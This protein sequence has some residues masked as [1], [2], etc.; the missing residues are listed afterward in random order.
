MKP[1]CD[2]Y[3]FLQKMNLTELATNEANETI[4]REWIRD[5]NGDIICE[6]LTEDELFHADSF[7]WWVEGIF[8]IVVGAI[9]FIANFAAIPILCSK[10][11]ISM[12]NRLLT[13]L[14]IIDNVF[15]AVSIS[16]AVRRHIYTR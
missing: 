4:I 2:S 13:C 1:D 3:V 10:E 12:F 6:D 7:G 11:M 16:E 9:G 15:I 8:Q 14:A 5:D